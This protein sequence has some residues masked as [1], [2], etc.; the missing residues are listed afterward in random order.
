MAS[1]VAKKSGGKRFPVT[2]AGVVL[3][4]VVGLAYVVAEATRPRGLTVVIANV[5]DAK[6]PTWPPPVWRWPDERTVFVWRRGANTGDKFRAVTAVEG[7]SRFVQ[8]PVTPPPWMGPSLAP[9]L[10]PDRSWVAWRTTGNNL[11]RIYIARLDGTPLADF[12]PSDGY[13]D[14]L[15][16]FPDSR[17]FAAVP[18]PH[19]YQPNLLVYD[20]T[21]P[22]APPVRLTHPELRRLVVLGKTL[23]PWTLGFDAAGVATAVDTDAHRAARDGNYNFGAGTM[24]L[25]FVTWG[26][27][28]DAPEVRLLRFT[29]T[30]GGKD[31]APAAPFTVRFPTGVIGVYLALSPDGRRIAWVTNDLIPDSW[32]RRVQRALRNFASFIPRPDELRLRA[33]VSDADG[34]DPRELAALPTNGRFDPHAPVWLPGGGAFSFLCGKSLYKVEVGGAR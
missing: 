12:P 15:A 7:S 32:P 31:A 20:V 18:A 28:P 16:P 29:P 22:A 4:G 1:G 9:S 13:V 27:N 23:R 5:Y 14:N 26:P 10:A 19:S 24:H 2:L 6:Q 34:G 8:T 17:R 3:A 30:E 33:W 11:G 21:A 25:S